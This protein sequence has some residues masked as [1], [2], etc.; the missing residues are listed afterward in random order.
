MTLRECWNLALTSIY[1]KTWLSGARQ[2][3]RKGINGRETS[4]CGSGDMHI[5]V[6]HIP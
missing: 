6:M 3:R 1:R 4:V 2:R 5:P